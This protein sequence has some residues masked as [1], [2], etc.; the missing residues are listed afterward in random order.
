MLTESCHML[1][2]NWN[3]MGATKGEEGAT[4]FSIVC[5]LKYFIAELTSQMEQKEEELQ[6]FPQ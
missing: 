2:Q 1:I 3:L 6:H 4:V 5:S